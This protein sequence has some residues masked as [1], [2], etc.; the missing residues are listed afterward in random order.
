MYDTSNP[1]RS[2]NMETYDASKFTEFWHTINVL[3]VG[4]VIATGFIDD[5]LVYFEKTNEGWAIAQVDNPNVEDVY[6]VGIV[7]S[8]SAEI[9]AGGDIE[10]AYVIREGN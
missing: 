8:E 7:V 2:W 4:S 3:P 10:L 5:G 1:V 6:V 9:D